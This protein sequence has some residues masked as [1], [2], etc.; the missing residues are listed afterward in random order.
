MLALCMY[1]CQSRESP[2]NQPVGNFSSPLTILEYI[3]GGIFGMGLVNS[4]VRLGSHWTFSCLWLI[5][6]LTDG[7]SFSSMM[8]SWPVVMGEIRIQAMLAT[9][10][11]I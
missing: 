5:S 10:E 1:M 7:C 11:T 6:C 3:H 9:G 2:S 8:D 4:L